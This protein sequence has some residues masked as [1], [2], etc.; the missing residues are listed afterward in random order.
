M[1]QNKEVNSKGMILYFGCMFILV[2]LSIVNFFTK[3]P[4]SRLIDTGIILIFF[5]DICYR[6]KKSEKPLQY[7]RTHPLDFI[8]LIPVS[9]G[10][11][12]FKIIPLT[13][14]ALRFTSIGKHYF[15]PVII[16]LKKT[17]I[18]RAFW[19]FVL[20]IFLLPLPLLWYE[21]GIKDYGTL[22]WW[23]LE[24]VTTVGYGDITIHTGIGRFIASILM[25]LGVGIISTVTSS[26]TQ[27]MTN[28]DRIPKKV[29]EYSREG[30]NDTEKSGMSSFSLK[31]VEVLER[32]LAKE[33][34]QIL[35]DKKKK[36]K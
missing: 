14:Q 12:T 36:S 7:I 26:L 22:M 13:I 9:G 30:I 3:S 16:E 11:R 17:V 28:P 24:T 25:I 27:V 18:G 20:L 4:Y 10:F 8:A 6:I 1:T 23:T 15:F 2:I 35:H 29:K 31:E 34:E 19:Y 21:P 32:L 5:M 33:K